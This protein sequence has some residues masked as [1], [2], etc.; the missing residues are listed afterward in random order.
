[1]NNPGMKDDSKERET[2]RTLYFVMAIRPQHIT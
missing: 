1:M 2:L